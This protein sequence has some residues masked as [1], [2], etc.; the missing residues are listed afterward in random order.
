MKLRII[1]AR[2]IMNPTGSPINGS[3]ASITGRWSKPPSSII[4]VVIIAKS[5]TAVTPM[6]P[7][8]KKFSSREVLEEAIVK[9]YFLK[10]TP[11]AG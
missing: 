8:A 3:W 4:K 11:V 9:E 6:A 7:Y 10:S 5:E 1:I 2:I